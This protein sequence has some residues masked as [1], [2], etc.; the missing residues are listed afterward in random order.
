MSCEWH[1]GLKCKSYQINY[2][3]T[4]NSSSALS[5]LMI[6]IDRVFIDLKSLRVVTQIYRLALKASSSSSVCLGG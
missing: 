2:R 3:D 5:F 1:F 4:N 6:K